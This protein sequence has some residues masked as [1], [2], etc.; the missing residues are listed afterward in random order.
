MEERMEGEVERGRGCPS[1]DLVGCGLLQFLLYNHLIGWC[2]F[3]NRTV[4]PGL[5]EP[6]PRVECSRMLPVPSS[7]RVII[8]RLVTC[9]V[10]V[11]KYLAKGFLPAHGSRRHIPS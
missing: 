3:Q 4:C 5:P 1:F 2:H 9:L 8:T 10:A 6:W 7:L 11:A